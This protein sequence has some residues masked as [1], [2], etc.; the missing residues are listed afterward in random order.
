MSEAA[1]RLQTMTLEELQT[2]KQQLQEK[3]E[4]YL[5]AM[6]SFPRKQEEW[7]SS[8]WAMK[9]DYDQILDLVYHVK[10]EIIN[11][12]NGLRDKDI[13]ELEVISHEAYRR[14]RNMQN[15]EW[16]VVEHSSEENQ[17]GF[18]NE[19]NDLE[20]L[21]AAANLEIERKLSITE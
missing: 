3:R 5:D 16:D 4:K 17:Q 21:E 9:Q 14:A 15:Y 13:A 12:E 20:M 1:A 6:D 7:L 11:R 10:L 19:I 8:E 2:Y 18:W